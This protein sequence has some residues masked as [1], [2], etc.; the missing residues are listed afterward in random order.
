M[1]G[2]DSERRVKPSELLPHAKVETCK[3]KDLTLVPEGGATPY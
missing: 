3:I 1:L 2:L